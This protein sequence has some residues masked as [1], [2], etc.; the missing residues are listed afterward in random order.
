VS[1]YQFYEDRDTKRN[2]TE[3]LGKRLQ[4]NDADRAARL[5]VINK[6]GQLIGE[7][8]KQIEQLK[9]KTWCA[10]V[11]KKLEYDGTFPLDSPASGN[12]F[13]RDPLM[14]FSG[15]GGILD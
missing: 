15:I 12:L 8:E 4:E 13:S 14:I 6:Q 11:V 3:Y 7:F 2:V 1:S 9:I 10:E 5:G